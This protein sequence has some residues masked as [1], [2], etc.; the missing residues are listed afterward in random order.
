MKTIILMLAVVVAGLCMVNAVAT[1]QFV[2]G[3]WDS[4]YHASTAAEGAATGMAN[5]ISAQGQYNLASSQ[6]V[7]NMEE[8]KRQEI[9]NRAKWTNAYFDMRRANKAYQDSLKKSIDPENALRFAESQKPKR[10]ALSDLG[11]S[12]DIHWPAGLSTDK[13]AG[14]RQDLDK[15]FAERAQKGSLSAQEAAQ[16]R[17]VTR[18][19]IDGLKAE[20]DAM[21][22]SDYTKAKQF[23]VSL[24]YEASLP[25]N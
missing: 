3:G 13:F 16:V 8:A 21:Q 7:I 24:S 14:Q 10:L 19:M 4:G 1:A 22:P 2:V 23:V 15:L 25:V 6:A 20:I 17:D 9:D 5:V 11:V 12:G 18:T